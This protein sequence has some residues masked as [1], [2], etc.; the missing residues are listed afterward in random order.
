MLKSMMQ[1]PDLVDQSSDMASHIHTEMILSKLKQ[2]FFCY[3]GVIRIPVNGCQLQNE[4]FLERGR[5]GGGGGGKGGEK[6]KIMQGKVEIHKLIE[7]PYPLFLDSYSIGILLVALQ[8]T[9][10]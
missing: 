3:C 9:K 7:P 2:F 8:L 10:V 5:G 4:F 1:K 6:S